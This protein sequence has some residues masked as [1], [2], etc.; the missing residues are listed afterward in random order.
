M[1]TRANI[2]GKKVVSLN[3]EE[4]GT[5]GN[6]IPDGTATGIYNSN[7]EAENELVKEKQIYYH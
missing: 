3:I 5:V 4:A 1:R 6:D 7:K 2:L